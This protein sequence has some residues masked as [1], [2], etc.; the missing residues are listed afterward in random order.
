M[1]RGEGTKS[2]GSPPCYGGEEQRRRRSCRDPERSAAKARGGS[3]SPRGTELIRNWVEQAVLLRRE[4]LYSSGVKRRC[5]SGTS[6]KKAFGLEARCGED[7]E[8]PSVE[9]LK[10]LRKARMR[11]PRSRAKPGCWGLSSQTGSTLARRPRRESH[12][13]GDMRASGHSTYYLLIWRPKQTGETY[14]CP[15][16]RRGTAS[17]GR[18]GEPQASGTPEAI[19]CLVALRGAEVYDAC[20]ALRPW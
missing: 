6:L 14:G 15:R 13:Q 19:W 7:C 4:A 2:G 5:W 16:I 11:H 12:V 18:A 20:L 8:G 1:G 3:S 9:R 10:E 17:G